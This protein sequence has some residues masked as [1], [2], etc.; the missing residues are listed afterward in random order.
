MKTDKISSEPSMTVRTVEA[1]LLLAASQRSP[2][3]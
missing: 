2:S 3:F 1:M